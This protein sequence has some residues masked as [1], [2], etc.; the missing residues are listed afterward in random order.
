[1]EL[2]KILVIIII[3]DYVTGILVAI[4]QRKISSEIGYKG[5]IKKIGIIICVIMCKLIEVLPFENIPSIYQLS[6]L[7]FSLNESFS[8]LENLYKLE[9]PLPR[10]IFKVLE[11]YQ[12]KK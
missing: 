11:K 12:E 8:I 7:F 1:M 10:Q 2:V 9:V 6:I 4:Y 5:I 3:L